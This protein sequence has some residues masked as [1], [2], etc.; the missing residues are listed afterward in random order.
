MF[1]YNVH[2]S[3]APWA[4]HPVSVQCHLHH[5]SPNVSILYLLVEYVNF[6]SI[7]LLDVIQPFSTRSSSPRLSLLSF[8]LHMYPN[9]FSFVSMICCTMF[10]LHDTLLR[11]SSFVIFC[12]I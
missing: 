10:F 6:L 7:P 2:P 12:S 4:Q 8:I 5:R 11:T 9:K 3:I 1:L